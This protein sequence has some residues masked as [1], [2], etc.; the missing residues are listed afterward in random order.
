M[1]ATQIMF[2]LV[3]ALL[4][5]LCDGFHTQFRLALQERRLS[6]YSAG[7]RSTASPHDSDDWPGCYQKGV[8]GKAKAVISRR[9]DATSTSK[10]TSKA[11]LASLPE[12]DSGDDLGHQSDKFRSGFVSILG[13]PNVGKSTLMNRLLGENLCIV[14]PKPQTTRHR[15]LG[16]L[17]VDPKRPTPGTLQ[18]E[19]T[20][21][22]NPKVSCYAVLYL[23]RVWRASLV[24]CVLLVGC[25]YSSPARYQNAPITGDL[26]LGVITCL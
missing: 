18:E 22:A 5:A 24:R 11:S 6:L 9:Q 16:I 25:R 2:I 3:V 4:V 23:L 19:K 17:T 26:A 14:S 15:T 1:L 10:T 12:S 7:L 21:S 13:N 20:R 8:K